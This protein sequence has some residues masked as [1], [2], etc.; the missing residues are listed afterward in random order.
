MP[1]EEGCQVRVAEFHTH[2][3]YPARL[4]GED[5]GY[6]VVHLLLRL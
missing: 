5:G 2:N 3:E 4:P 6:A 1:R